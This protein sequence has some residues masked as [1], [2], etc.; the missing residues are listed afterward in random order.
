MDKPRPVNVV[1]RVYDSRNKKYVHVG[2]LSVY[3]IEPVTVIE[4]LRKVF[5]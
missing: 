5:K 3:N 2:S 4:K 1:V